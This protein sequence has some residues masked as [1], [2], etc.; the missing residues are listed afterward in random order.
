MPSLAAL[1]PRAG[2]RGEVHAPDVGAVD[3][4]VEL[5]RRDV[6]MPEQLLHDTVIF[7]IN[8]LTLVLYQGL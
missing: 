4:G 5:R 8:I 2:V 7:S 6:G 1:L 3:V